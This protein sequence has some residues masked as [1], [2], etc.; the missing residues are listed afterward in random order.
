MGRLEREYIVEEI[1]KRIKDSENIIISN[2]SNIKAEELNDLRTKLAENESSY[3]VVKNSLCKLAL[4]KADKKELLDLI[5]GSTG[6]VF[7]KDN[8]IS[9]S[10]AIVEFSKDAEGLKILGG[11]IEG[12]VVPGGQVKELAALPSQKELLTMLVTGM[13]YPITSFVGTLGQLVKKFVFVL[14][15]V[16]KKKEQE[17]PQEEAAESAANKKA[18]DKD[19]SEETKAEEGAVKEETGSEAVEKPREVKNEENNDTQKEIPQ[20]TEDKKDNQN[21]EE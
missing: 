15:E 13:K 8:L 16:A 12:E 2:F 4:E 14:N 19:T 18:A 11:L 7:C 1:S 10:K 6:F 9:A 20:E 3:F 17:A 5:S 21:K